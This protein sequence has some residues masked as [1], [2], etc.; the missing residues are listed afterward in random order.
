MADG[1]HSCNEWRTRRTVEESKLLTIINIVFPL[2][3]YPT[4]LSLS[5][6]YS[7]SLHPSSIPFSL[8]FSLSFSF[9]SHQYQ[10]L[11]LTCL[12]SLECRNTLLRPL[13]SSVLRPWKKEVS[14]YFFLSMGTCPAYVSTI[15]VLIYY[16]RCTSRSNHFRNKIYIYTGNDI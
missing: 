16:F 2:S 12:P 5:L 7:L 10:H 13:S 3:S 15:R 6:S 14:S 11:V 9:D 4:S 1:I 8:F